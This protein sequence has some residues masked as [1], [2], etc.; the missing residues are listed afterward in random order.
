MRARSVQAQDVYRRDP[1]AFIDDLITRTELGKPFRL[2]S[3]QRTILRRA[4][5][6][7]RGKLAFTTVVWS[8]IKKS[9][10]TTIAAVMGL[11]WAY[12]QE[13]PN[14]VFVMANDFDQA[15]SR[16]FTTMVNLIRQNPGL[17]ESATIQRDRITL[18]NGTIIRALP[19]DYAGAAGSNHGLTIWEEIWGYDSERATRLWEELTPVATRRNSIRFV[20][21]YA[22]FENESDLL[23]R[24]YRQGVGPEEHPDGQGQRIHATLPVYANREA[25]L[26]VY[27]SHEPRMPWQKA[28]YYR[29]QRA[30]LR[31]SQFLRLHENRWASTETAFIT[32]EMWAACL[33]PD[34]RPLLPGRRD[35]ELY[36]GVDV[37]T[38]HDSSA[39]VAV[40]RDR[41]QD[42]RDVVALAAH[43]IWRP[44]PTDPLDIEATV[45]AYLRE[46]HHAYRVRAVLVDP[47]QMARSIQTL[48]AA[49]LRVE[50]YPQT[51]DRLTVMGQAVYDLVQGRNLSVYAAAD[52]REHAL[53]AV[54]VESAR[55]WRIAKEK[56]SKKVDGLVALAMAC[57]A[58]GQRPAGFEPL[59]WNWT[60]SYT[61]R[62]VSNLGPRD[63]PLSPIDADGGGLVVNPRGQIE[64]YRDA[65][66]DEPVVRPPVVHDV[67]DSGH[68]SCCRACRSAFLRLP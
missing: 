64:I 45:E 43:R 58:L 50:E 65:R 6:F 39:V 11:W 29:E 51:L 63:A 12:T 24:L 60:K 10:K 17:R 21:T 26:F 41:D 9:G 54:V 31:P 7:R 48:K 42:G 23:Q 55:G 67:Q 8:E 27:W 38:K 52:L 61:A 33:D 28:E 35:A 13:P 36:V 18:S 15:V 37:A 53:N 34:R 3:H 30:T 16:V 44:T 68:R 20:A 22:G 59:V 57:A 49:G 66:G 2:L 25:K 14:E 46:L 62:T 56:S 47:Y 4:F 19:S 1:I 5:T 32:A 40:M